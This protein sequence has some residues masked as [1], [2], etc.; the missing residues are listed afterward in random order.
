MAV[1]D[2]LAR[3]NGALDINTGTIAVPVWTPVG[4][5]NSWNPNPTVAE[6]DTT[7]FSS[8]GRHEGMSAS[9]TDTFTFS[10]FTQVD[11]T[12]GDR[13]PG[14][15]ACEL[16]SRQLGQASRRQFRHSRAGGKVSTFLATVQVVSGG[17]GN[18]DPDAWSVELRVSGEIATAT[19]AVPTVVTSPTATGATGQATINWTN[20]AEVGTLFEVVVYQG[21]S[22]VK[23][24]L[25][26]NKPALVSLPAGSGYT[27]QVRAGNLAGWSALSAASSSF[28]VS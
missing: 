22:I 3:D 9:T 14:Q 4:G 18:D 1:T 19:P 24:V 27:A 17:G 10:G 7:K 2:T 8:N 25:S 15:L 13:D 5:I 11:E 12:T 16:Q 20:G 28:T 23:Q 26:S 21:G 6:A